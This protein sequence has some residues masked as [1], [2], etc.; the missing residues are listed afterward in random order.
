MSQRINILI[1]EDEAVLA[2]DLDEQLTSYGY[3]VIGTARSGQQALAL[4]REHRVD[5]ILCDI[6]LPGEWDGIETVTEL[7][8]LRLVPVIYITGCSYED[9]FVRAQRTNPAAFLDKPYTSETLRWAVEMALDTYSLRQLVPPSASDSQ[10]SIRSFND[11]IVAYSMSQHNPEMTYRD[12]VFIKQMGSFIRVYL[13]EILY[14]EAGDTYTTVVTRWQPYLVR[15]ALGTVLSQ[16]ATNRLIRTHRAF[17]VNLDQVQLFNEWEVRV[18]DR[19][20]PLGRT[21]RAAFL[22]N[23]PYC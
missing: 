13:D 17:A 3:H 11:D 22:E 12:T 23:F 9:T 21:Y 10:G 15:L 18:G 16:L 5:L 6:G 4:F 8:Y 7:T 2:M 20:L 1:I 19:T 14:L